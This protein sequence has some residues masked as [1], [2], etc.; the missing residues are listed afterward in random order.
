MNTE[1]ERRE[2][3]TRQVKERRSLELSQSNLV[4]LG[5]NGHILCTFNSQDL[6]NL[7]KENR[8]DYCESIRQS[9]GNFLQNQFP[10][11][12]WKSENTKNKNG[13]LNYS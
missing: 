12:S 13:L 3:Y 10:Y 5:V 9:I 4:N 2:E 8:M 1:D 6:E 7:K 11:F